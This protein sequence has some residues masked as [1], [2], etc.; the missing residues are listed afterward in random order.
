MI[1]LIPVPQGTFLMGASENDLFAYDNEKPQKEYSIE[2]GLEISIFPITQ[3]QFTKV[4]GYNPSTTSYADDKPVDNVSWI[5]AIN[6][7]NKLSEFYGYSPF[8]EKNSQI[9]NCLQTNGFRLP[10]EKEWE[11]VCRANTYTRYFFGDDE[12]LLEEY[13][14]Y[15]ENSD[16][17]IH[18][19]GLKKANPFGLY[20]LYGNVWE[21]CFDIYIHKDH[22]NDYKEKWPKLTDKA[23]SIYKNKTR[24][25]RGGAFDLGPRSLRSSNRDVCGIT[26]RNKANSFRVIRKT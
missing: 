1:E 10:F 17:K 20:D 21:W 6:F 12:N 22:Y 7:C 11:Y 19:V 5:E 3:M 23:V 15:R 2:E 13:A 26:F 16:N 25:L 9:I 14:W 8:Y 18:P 4:A 24:I